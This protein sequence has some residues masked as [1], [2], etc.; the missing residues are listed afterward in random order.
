MLQS[1]EQ[2]S[3][4][5]SVLRKLKSASLNVKK[6]VTAAAAETAAATKAV[7][8]RFIARAKHQVELD[9]SGPRK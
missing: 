6:D 2:E 8:H 4:Q 9:T 3:T 1:Q 5:A 7:G